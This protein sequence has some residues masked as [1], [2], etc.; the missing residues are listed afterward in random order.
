[1]S[2]MTQSLLMEAQSLRLEGDIDGSIALLRVVVSQCVDD[3]NREGHHASNELHLKMWQM[4]SYQLALLLLQK[5]GRSGDVTSSEVEAEADAILSKLGYRSR[6][7]VKA[8]GYPTCDCTIGK[9]SCIK[10]TSIPLLVIDDALPQSIFDALRNSLRP[11][12]RYWTE[13]YVK[14]TCNDDEDKHRTFASHNIPL[15]NSTNRLTS[16]QLIENS[17]SLIEQIAIIVKHRLS[18]R[19]P[20]IVSA[21]SVEVWSH[22]RPPDAHHQLHYDMD[23]IALWKYKQRKL[24]GH[25]SN[26]QYGRGNKRQKINHRTEDEESEQVEDCTSSV[27]YRDLCP[28]VSCAL[29]VNVP[30]ETKSCENCNRFG[31]G[32]PTLVCNQHLL[33]NKTNEGWLCYPRLNRLVAF[34]GSLLHGVLPGIPAG[35]TSADEDNH[36]VTLMLGFWKDVT[37]T[38]ED[39][40]SKTYTIGPNVPLP[41]SLLD[42]F[43]PAVVTGSLLLS[44]NHVK[45]PILVSPL[46]KDF[47]NEQAADLDELRIR[48]SEF[49]GR[50]FRKTSDL[51]DIDKE[52]LGYF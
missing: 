12:S 5:S 23:E 47:S 24:D 6:L 43:K 16:M 20:S 37:L 2:L 15:P 48:N 44:A 52:I 45:D 26:K 7:S 18:H 17:S 27:V 9:S 38:A 21:T 29:T 25:K 40:A 34:D 11:C 3:A 33:G 36:R 8:F 32:A 19:F 1:M 51:N 28:I 39:N 13:F 31:D 49:K 30:N 4:A 42:E 22:R 50:F 46:W 14:T 35:D 10:K 41:A